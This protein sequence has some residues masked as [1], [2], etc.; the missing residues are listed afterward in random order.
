MFEINLLSEPGLQSID[1]VNCSVSFIK[2]N[3]VN[4]SNIASVVKNDKVPKEKAILFPSVSLY[5][6][7]FVAIVGVIFYPMLSS[8]NLNIPL[9]V[10]DVSQEVV[11]DN[12]IKVL[13]QSKN[14]YVINSLQFRDGNILISLTSF[15]ITLMKFFQEELDFSNI[16]AIRVFGDTGSYS[17]IAKLPW[18]IIS[19]DGS[20]HSP[21][22]FFQFVNTG[23]NVQT[24]ISENEIDN[25]Q[26]PS[27]GCNIK[28][29]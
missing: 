6:I 20:I 24:L 28:W 14:D 23:K 15:D 16:G 12:I 29:K 11:I 25:N 3:L 19:N 26:F 5:T 27:M 21:E 13:L 4:S 2:P 7:I 1:T 22:I 9:K 18:E 10:E 8:I 17:M